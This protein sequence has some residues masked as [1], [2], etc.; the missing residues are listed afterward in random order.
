[1]RP[2]RILSEPYPGPSQKRHGKWTIMLQTD[3]GLLTIEEAADL[4][5][6]TRN[7][8]YQRLF[9]NKRTSWKHANV[10]DDSIPK[11]RDYSEEPN[12]PR[13]PSKKVREANNTIPIGTWERRDRIFS[14]YRREQTIKGLPQRDRDY[15]DALKFNRA[16]AR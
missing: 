13:L 15:N 5:G 1:M 7:V 6:K 12:T 11:G 9:F 2:T 3:V 4:I 14:M 16:V 8:L 10:F